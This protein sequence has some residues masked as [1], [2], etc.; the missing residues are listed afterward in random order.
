M[1]IVTAKGNQDLVQKY[2]H[3]IGD[4]IVPECETNFFRLKPR[5]DNSG[6]VIGT[7]I[8]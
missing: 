3:L 6:N 8:V 5:Y 4:A 7:L 2:T 1:F